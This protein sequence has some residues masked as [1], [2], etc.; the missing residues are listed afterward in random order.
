MAVSPAAFRVGSWVAVGTAA[1]GTKR[2]TGRR[3]CCCA[4]RGT[5]LPSAS[6]NQMIARSSL[7]SVACTAVRLGT[8]PADAVRAHAGADTARFNFLGPVAQRSPL[9]SQT[10]TVMPTSSA[11]P[12]SRGRK[13][14]Q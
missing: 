3:R 8:A 11:P 12:R 1:S 14:Q 7:V 10:G 13:D 2:S 4:K 5:E 9:A 6:A